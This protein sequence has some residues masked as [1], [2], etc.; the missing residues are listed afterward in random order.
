MALELDLSADKTFPFNVVVPGTYARIDTIVISRVNI[1]IQVTWYRNAQDGAAGTPALCQRSYSFGSYDP[2]DPRP[3]KE[4]LYNFL[5][6][7]PDFQG[8]ADV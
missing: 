6:T 7:L 2:N 3:V 8:A 4:T 5:K 1:Q